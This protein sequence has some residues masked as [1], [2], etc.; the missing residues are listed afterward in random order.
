MF[1]SFWLILPLFYFEKNI[2]KYI[3]SLPRLT[4]TKIVCI[5]H[6]LFF[7]LHLKICKPLYITVQRDLPYSFLH[8]HSTSLRSDNSLFN[9][10]PMNDVSYLWKQDF[11][12]EDKHL[13][14]LDIAKSP[15]TE[16]ETILHSHWPCMRLLFPPT[17]L[18]TK[19][20]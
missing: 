16:F 7:T 6:I 5:P 11:W 14:L 12:V 9:K 10:S 2:S 3:Y 18:P 13:V 19:C 1:I 15:S 20:V 4:Y 8:L 17:A